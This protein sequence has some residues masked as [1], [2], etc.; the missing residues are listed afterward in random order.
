MNGFN[1]SFLCFDVVIYFV[2]EMLLFVIDV[3]KVFMWIIIVGF[4][5]GFFIVFVIFVNVLIIDF[6]GDYLIFGFFY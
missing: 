2:E 5:F 4:G 1:W 3:L 6:V